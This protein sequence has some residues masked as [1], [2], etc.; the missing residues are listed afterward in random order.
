MRGF[1]GKKVHAALQRLPSEQ[2]AGSQGER[3]QLTYQIFIN[4]G[5]T[6]KE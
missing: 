4:H 5:Q 1:T 3:G 6:N 2:P